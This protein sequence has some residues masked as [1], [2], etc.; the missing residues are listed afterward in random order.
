MPAKP[1][2]W[3]RLNAPMPPLTMFSTAPGPR[4]KVAPTVPA[5]V[6]PATTAPAP[7]MGA[8]VAPLATLT[9]VLPRLPPLP[10]WSAPPLALTVVSPV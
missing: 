5:P 10:T 3:L 4:F 2:C 1:D 9:A 6:L 8:K 7:G